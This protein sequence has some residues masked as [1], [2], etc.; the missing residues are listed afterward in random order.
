MNIIISS[1]NENLMFVKSFQT[2][3]KVKIIINDLLNMFIN[4]TI[5]LVTIGIIVD[6]VSC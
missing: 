2:S 1:A 3:K 6:K 4:E 5:K